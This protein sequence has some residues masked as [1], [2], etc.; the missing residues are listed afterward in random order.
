M[1]IPTPSPPLVTPGG[2]ALSD[3]EKA[4]ALADSL[5]AQFQPVNNPSVPAVIERVNEAMRAYSFAPASEP[6]L[7]NCMEVQEAIRGLKVGKAPGPDGIPNR[8]LK[9]LPLSVV[10]LLV[11]LFN[12]I[13]QTHHFPAPWKHARVFSILKPG[14]DPA[15]P[16]SYR[17]ISLL[18]T[19]GKLFEKILLSR[20]LSEVSGR[21]LLRDEQFG[22]RP[23][24]S[25]A[26]QLTRL[27]ERV[28]RNFDER[29]LTGAVFLDVAKAFDT[30][31]VDGLLYKLTTLNF[32]SYLVKTISSYLNGRTFEASFQTATSTSRSMHAGVAQGGIISPVLFSL[33]VNDM[34]SP[35]RHIE[36]ALYA[37]DTAIIATSRKPTL[38]VKYL[39]TYLSDLERWLS[40]WRIAINVSKSS[41]MLFV[42]ARRIQQ[43]R[44]VRLF[45]EPIQWVNEARYLGVTLDKRLTWSKHVGQV[46]RKAAQRL[47]IL[48]SLLN[49][50]NGLSIRNGVLLYKQLIRPMMDYACPVWRSAACS[51][52]NKLQ[53]LQSKCLRIATNAPW[54]ISNRQIHDDLGV[55]YFSEHIRSL[56]ERFDSK[57]ADVGNPLIEHLGNRPR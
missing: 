17:P 52:V 32:P 10:S 45:G 40:E 26:L 27:V 12:A 28:S 9:R 55:P 56:T 35:S 47:G 19:I 14:K 20:I 34:P 5:E 43:P 42:K 31:W 48:G 36:L 6:R 30:V 39:E 22:F 57:L 7:T 25:T 37:D 49:R 53:A 33:Y 13:L 23:R 50:R 15:Q 24:H 46:R 16:S 44:P 41:A 11:V 29:R 8:A 54:Y 1:R 18:D 2:L 21:G 51:H 3:C 38:L 4:E